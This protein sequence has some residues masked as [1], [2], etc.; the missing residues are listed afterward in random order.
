MKTL[1]PFSAYIASVPPAKRVSSSGCAET[2]KIDAISILDSR[3]L[4]RLFL[5][6]RSSADKIIK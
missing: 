1:C 4:F 3:F 5:P 6:K 2:A